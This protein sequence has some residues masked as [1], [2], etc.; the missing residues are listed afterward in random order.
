M[1]VSRNNI[2]A[3]KVEKCRLAEV[4]ILRGG[5]AFRA[6]IPAV[7]D[8]DVPVIQVKDFEAGHEAKWSRT[9][10]TVLSR[11]PSPDEWLRP[12]DILFAFRG[13]RFFAATLDDVPHRA[14]ASSQFMIIRVKDAAM[15]L[16]SFLAW[17]LN[18]PPSRTYFEESAEGTA[19]RSLRRAA[20]E[21]VS[22]A[23]PGTSIQTSIVELAAL[24]KR[25]RAVLEELIQVREQQ[26]NQISLSLLAAVDRS[27]EQ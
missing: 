24:G 15:L 16:P 21:N 22:I 12:G 2:I 17:Q 13:T 7:A 4:A 20:I 18:S 3:S 14:I 10:R 26:L 25:E 9:V 11:E 1:S 6:A 23:I 27:R 19:Q 5:Y 8:G